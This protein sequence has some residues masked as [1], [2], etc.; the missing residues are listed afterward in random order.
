MKSIEEE[1][2]KSIKSIKNPAVEFCN[3]NDHFGNVP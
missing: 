2:S 3:C 1:L